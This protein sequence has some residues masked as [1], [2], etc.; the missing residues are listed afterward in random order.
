M[1]IF[2][3]STM[4]GLTTIN[5]APINYHDPSPS[6]QGGIA[7]ITIQVMQ[8]TDPAA[9]QVGDA[10]KATGG[11][12]P[13]EQA[14]GALPTAEPWDNRST[15]GVRQSPQRKVPQLIICK[16]YCCV[17]IIGCGVTVLVL[18]AAG[19]LTGILPH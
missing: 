19:Y 9:R 8:A 7:T 10:S 18:I 2:F 3:W 11:Q 12:S 6:A 15:E 5:G 17:A 14:L 16:K 4:Y 1:R 13:P